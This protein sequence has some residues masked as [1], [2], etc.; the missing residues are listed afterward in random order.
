[1]PWLQSHLLRLL[2]L[3]PQQGCLPPRAFFPAPPPQ[4]AV[5][6]FGYAGSE[7]TVLSDQQRPAQLP[8]TGAVAVHWVQGSLLDR[9]AYERAG[10]PSAHSVILGSVHAEDPKAADA[11]MLTSLLMV[12]VRWWAGLGVVGRWGTEPKG[13]A[14]GMA[15]VVVCVWGG[16]GALSPNCPPGCWQRG[17]GRQG[18]SPPV[19]GSWHPCCPPQAA[20]QAAARLPAAG[21][22]QRPRHLATHRRH[23]AGGPWQQLLGCR[24]GMRPV[25]RCRQCMRPPCCGDFALGGA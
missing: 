3:P 15:A 18:R 11:R 10:V 13:L 21:C 17:T 20:A 2:L 6:D 22:R 19:L 1:M 12:Q 24:A 4:T 14:G 7:I 25:L 23:H 9:A 5:Q 16:G 8:A